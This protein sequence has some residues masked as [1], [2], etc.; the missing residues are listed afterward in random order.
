M[1]AYMNQ[2]L[3]DNSEGH[4]D[5]EKII[6]ESELVGISNKVTPDCTL[7][8]ACFDLTRFN[9]KSRNLNES[10]N[11]M[12]TLLSVPCY[13][14][15]YTD[16]ICIDLIKEIRNSFN[17][18]H[19]THYIVT[20]IE[21]LSN[22]KYLDTIKSN[23]EKYWPTRDERTSA[24]SHFI[25]CSKFEF[26]LQTMEKN[27]F[28]TTRFGWIDANLNN[29]FSKI[30]EGFNI[31]MLMNILHNSSDK[32]HIQIL[33][34]NDKKYKNKEDKREYYERY[35]WVVCG[36]LF[37]TGKEIGI[38]VLNR[39]NQSFIETTILGYG[40]GEEMLY[41]E[42]LDE[43]YDDI[44]R[45]YGDYGQIVN[46]YFYPTRNLY[47]INHL[48]I[49]NYLNSYY[50]RECY[51]CCEYML[52]GIENHNVNCD[53]NFYMDILHSYFV[54]SYYYKINESLRIVNHIYDV[55]EKNPAL[56][57]VFNSQKEFYESQFKLV[58]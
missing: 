58:K 24:E 1:S 29:N 20:N 2:N 51:D 7:T 36:C 25:C 27:P 38:K 35:R 56:K 8:T 14:V 13:L 11:H 9:N 15:I 39:L 5:M 34:V 43:F 19:L 52:N 30:C 21:D 31:D 6:S 40:H 10:I 26:V 50:H 49:R 22:Y 32:F 16:N 54:S 17:L 48:I 28:N 3:E 53:P 12:K 42:V 23:R 57:N 4:Q 18:E 37:I 55:C 46:N 47:Y 44:E 41:L 45:S 33:N